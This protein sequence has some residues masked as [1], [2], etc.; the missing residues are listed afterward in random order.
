MADTPEGLSPEYLNLVVDATCDQEGEPIRV[1]ARCLTCW[2][3]Y[4]IDAVAV[5]TLCRVHGSHLD[6]YAE[7]ISFRWLNSWAIAHHGPIVAIRHYD[8]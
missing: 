1:I 2:A 3:D 8:R 6:G 4:H 5:T 7:P